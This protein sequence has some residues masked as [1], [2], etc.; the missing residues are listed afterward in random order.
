MKILVFTTD[1]IPLEGLPTSGTALRTFGFIQGLRAN[2]HEVVVSVPRSALNGML[3]NIDMSSVAAATKKQ[4]DDLRPLAFDPTNQSY[5]VNEL[6]PD[7]ILCGHWP[8]YAFQTRPAQPVVVDLAGPHL[9]ERHYQ[10]TPNHL[11][12]ALSKLGVIASADH[13]IVSGPSQRRYFLAFAMRAGVPHPEKRMI[14]ITMPLSPQIPVRDF[15]SFPAAEYPRF[16]FGGVFLPW[17]DPSRALEQVSEHIREKQRGRLTLIGGSHPNYKIKEGIYTKLFATLSKN[18]AVEKLPMLPYDAFQARLAESDVAIDLMRWN[19]ERELAMT[20][21]S[22]TYLWAGVPIIYNDFADLGILLRKYD[23]GWTISPDQPDALRQVLDEILDNPEMVRR[24]SENASR[25][26]RE[27]FSWDLAVRPLLAQLERHDAGAAKETDIVL[28]FPD[29]ADLIVS[30]ERAVEQIFFSRVDGLSRIE[31]R[32]ATHGKEVT[33]PVTFSLYELKNSG[34]QDGKA[35][36]ALLASRSAVGRDLKNNEWFSLETAPIADSAGK[37]FALRIET[38][39]SP[40][41]AA[42]AP[43]A[44]RGRPFPLLKL[45]HGN[46]PVDDLSLC[47]RTTCSGGS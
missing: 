37:T 1:V 31:C 25:L 4:I 12:A 29:R 34:E 7:L 20:I 30:E 39:A 44:V 26:A 38:T 24:K 28:D 5:I 43:W 36:R 3:K 22:T 19:L 40:N 17:Q 32:M 15:S 41:S 45:I 35:T 23:A 10:G 42:V 33:D 8:A 6:Q 16:I 27:V 11:G 46:Q 21:R 18:P 13:F 2:G 14:E 9:L 47:L